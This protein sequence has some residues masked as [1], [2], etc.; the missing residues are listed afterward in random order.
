MV[1]V[2]YSD[3][4]VEDHHLLTAHALGNIP[5]VQVCRQENVA[6]QQKRNVFRLSAAKFFN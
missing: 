5:V 1:E 6:I 3:T 2:K 4:A